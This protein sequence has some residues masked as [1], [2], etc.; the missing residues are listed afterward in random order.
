MKFVDEATIRVAAGNGGNGTVSF[1]RE[2]YVPR[3]GPDGGDGGRGG[4]VWMLADSG[5]NTLAD[6]RFQRNFRAGHGQPGSGKNCAGR[7]AEDL[8]IQ[9]PVGTV[10]QDSGTGEIIGDLTRPDQR[11]LVARG[12]EGGQGT[13]VKATF[14]G[15]VQITDMVEAKS[16]TIS[17]EGKGGPAGFAKG[18]AD[19]ELTALDDGGTRLTYDVEAKVG[20][21]LAQL[22]S[23]IID[24]FAKK[25]ADQFFQNLQIAIEGPPEAEP[26][27][28]GEKKGWLGRLAGR[29]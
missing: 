16:C 1:R 21:K 15:A 12:G 4:S 9:V 5:I 17:G 22:G 23:R 18:G 27:G 26:G 14:K 3:G 28:E 10:V 2:K 6:F 11:L 7:G 19:V 29:S 25:M 8:V 20:G 24:G 13:A